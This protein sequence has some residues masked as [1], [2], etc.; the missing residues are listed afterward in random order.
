[1]GNVIAYTISEGKICGTISFK[2]EVFDT[3]NDRNDKFSI[4]RN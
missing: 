3:P 4:T 1:M 2:F